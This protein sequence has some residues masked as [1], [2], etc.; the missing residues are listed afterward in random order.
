MLPNSPVAIE[1]RVGFAFIP[2]FSVLAEGP[3]TSGADLIVVGAIRLANPAR[4]AD[5]LSGV[6][7]RKVALNTAGFL[8]D[9]LR[10]QVLADAEDVYVQ[11]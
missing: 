3:S 9:Y 10:D 7:G 5:E 2:L 11:A 6:L 1:K 4:D 8:G